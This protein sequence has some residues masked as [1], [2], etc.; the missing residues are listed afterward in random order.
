[1]SRD[2]EVVVVTGASAGVGRAVAR[3]FG[4]RRARVGL[5]ARGTDGLEAARKEIEA[6]GGQ[7]IVLP[8][9]VAEADKVELAAAEVE[10]TFGPIDVWVNNAMASVFSPVWDLEADEIRRV[11]EVTYLGTVYGTMAALKHMLPRDRGTIVQVGSALAYRSIPL[12]SA[13]CGAKHAIVGFT[14]SLRCE[15]LHRNSHLHLTIVQLPAMNTPQ[16]GWV[17]SRLPNKAQPVPPIYEP[18]VAARAI[19]WAAHHRRREIDVG[20]PTVE[21]ITANKVVPGLLARYLGKTGFKS[22]QTDEPRDPNQPDNLWHPVPGDHGAHGTF[23]K[24]SRPRSAQTWLT[25]HRNGVGMAA[26]LALFAA[27]V[28]MKMR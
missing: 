1:M 4:K 21:A 7:A 13:Y 12:Q 2:Q 25:L 5:I 24:R 3:E 22:Q 8:T 28:A 9:D 15:L 10:N 16:F 19:Y 23:T 6:C 26:G 27:G 18:E 20:W 14:D 11:T 17:K